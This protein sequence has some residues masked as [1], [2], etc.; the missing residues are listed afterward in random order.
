MLDNLHI[1]DAKVKERLESRSHQSSLIEMIDHDQE[2]FLK[3]TQLKVDSYQT[4]EQTE[5]KFLCLELIA[6]VNYAKDLMDRAAAVSDTDRLKTLKDRFDQQKIQIDGLVKTANDDAELD[7]LGKMATKILGYGLNVEGIFAQHAIELTSANLSAA[8]VAKNHEVAN[9]VNAATGDFS[10]IAQTRTNVSVTEAVQASRRALIWQA[11][12]AAGSILTAGLI[13]WLYIGPQIVVRLRD[14]AG[15]MR[16]IAGGTMDTPIPQ[17]GHDEITGMA[18]ALVVFRDTAIAAEA[19]KRRIEEQERQAGIR[20]REAM[21]E[22]AASF[23]RSVQSVVSEVT[24]TSANVYS[25]AQTVSSMAAETN[26]KVSIATRASG[27]A[28]RSST[29][30]AAAAEQLSMSI[31]EIS[32]QVHV[33]AKISQEAARDAGHTD[34]TIHSLTAAAQKIGE[35]IGVISSIASQTSLLAL[36]A[37][38]EAA[39]AGE[40][41]KGFAVVA[42]EV[43]NLANQTARATQDVGLQVTEIQEVTQQAVDTIKGIVTT[44]TKIEQIGTAIA[45]AVEEQQVATQEIARS[46][47]QTASSTNDVSIESGK[48]FPCRRPLRRLG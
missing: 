40:A 46:V 12:I 17:S 4:S 34:D 32:R 28:S 45:A 19:T 3:K 37:T 5:K 24:A 23:E 9:K 1:L 2:D 18:N 13:A 31:A 41:G 36:N 11:A 33:S 47:S 16:T 35:I 14:L 21:L 15:A 39:R 38:I 44:L 6:A 30:T 22:V 27:L 26:N 20:R 48:R 43:K 29:E 8:I 42:G 7:K 25:G 10:K